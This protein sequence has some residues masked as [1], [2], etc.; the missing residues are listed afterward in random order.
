MCK[1]K[2]KDNPKKQEKLEDFTATFS[3]KKKHINDISVDNNLNQTEVR[4]KSCEASEEGPAAM[5]GAVM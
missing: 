1:K 4:A 3:E 2:R 5:K